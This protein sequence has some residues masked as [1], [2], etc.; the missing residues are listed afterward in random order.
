VQCT[1]GEG[2]VGSIKRLRAMGMGG[3]IWWEWGLQ[4]FHDLSISS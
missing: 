3:S 2:A 1:H 4:Y